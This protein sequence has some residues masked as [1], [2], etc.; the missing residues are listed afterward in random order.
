MVWGWNYI[1]YEA[2]LQKIFLVNQG[3][4]KIMAPEKTVIAEHAQQ[5]KLV[6]V[7]TYVYGLTRPK[8]ISAMLSFLAL[9]HD[10]CCRNMRLPDLLTAEDEKSCMSLLD[11]VIDAFLRV[12][13]LP[14]TTQAQIGKN[15]L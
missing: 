15:G 9:C 12:E 7:L 10:V 8:A 11:K 1:F 4:A 3:P 6:P 14:E 2:I 13:N 5:E